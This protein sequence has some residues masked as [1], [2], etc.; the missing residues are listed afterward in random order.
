MRSPA[1]R[2]VIFRKVNLLLMKG[3]DRLTGEDLVRIAQVAE[4]AGAVIYISIPSWQVLL[5]VPGG[6]QEQV[7]EDLRERGYDSVKVA[8]KLEQG[9]AL[10]LRGKVSDGPVEY[11]RVKT[12]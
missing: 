8:R 11:R 4:E 9:S 7:L 12:G 6:Q 2:A 1:R 5:G 3:A 10:E